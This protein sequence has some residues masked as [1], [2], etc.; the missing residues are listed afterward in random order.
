MG[1]S[2]GAVRRSLQQSLLFF[3]RGQEAEFA[4]IVLQDSPGVRPEGDNEGLVSTLMRKGDEPLYHETV[5]EVDTVE[6]AGRS[7]HGFL[8]SE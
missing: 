1:R 7:N 5:S 2:A 3:E 6:K 4:G 8:R